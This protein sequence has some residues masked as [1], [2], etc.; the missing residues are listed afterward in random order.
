MAFPLVTVL[1]AAPGILFAA[2][3]IFEA[4]QDAIQ[5][6][7]DDSKTPLS[8]KVEHIGSLME[9][10]AKVIEDLAVNNNPSK[11]Y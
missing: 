9:E 5:K 11:G 6:W 3:E 1:K 4:V 2:K 10:Q 7:K 8:E